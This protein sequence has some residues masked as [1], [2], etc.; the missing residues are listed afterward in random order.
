MGTPFCR[1]SVASSRAS[2][3]SPIAC[4]I[5][6]GGH[7]SDVLWVKVHAYMF[8]QQQQQQ[9]NKQQHHSSIKNKTK[10]NV[11]KPT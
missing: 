5:V 10:Q 4:N 2:A 1:Y 11:P 8:N 6:E 9:R 7:V 3:C